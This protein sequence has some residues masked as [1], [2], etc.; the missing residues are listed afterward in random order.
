MIRNLNISFGTV[1]ILAG[2]STVANIIGQKTW[3]GLIDQFGNRAILTVT[4]LVLALE[5]IVWLFA[6]Q[7]GVGFAVV[8][9]IHLFA[10]ASNGGFLLSSATMMMSLAPTAGKN[11]FFAMHALVR[12]AS[13]A[14]GPVLAGLLLDRILNVVVPVPEWMGSAFTVI[15]LLAFS[16][17]LLSWVFLQNLSEPKEYPKLHVSVLFSEFVRSINIT[18]GHSLTPQSFSMEPAL[19]D[20]TIEQALIEAGARERRDT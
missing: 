19:D 16:G 11:S 4:C 8:I 7:T 12:G 2:L 5:P 9:M 13:A 15:F 10:G 1:A 18:Q 3:G 17:R 14:T 20:R 6:G